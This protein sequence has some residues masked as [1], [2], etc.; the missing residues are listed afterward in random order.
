[1]RH[2]D[3][4]YERKHGSLVCTKAGQQFDSFDRLPDDKFPFNL[5]ALESPHGISLGCHYRKLRDNYCYRRTLIASEHRCRA[6][7]I[8][9]ATRQELHV[10]TYSFRREATIEDFRSGLLAS[11]CLVLPPYFPFSFSLTLG[12]LLLA[13]TRCFF[14]S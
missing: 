1:M 7:Y 5:F 9:P 2:F 14:R 12:L 10:R 4:L 13:L 6:T 8:I 3:R 11:S